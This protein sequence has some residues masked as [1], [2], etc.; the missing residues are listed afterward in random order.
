[1]PTLKRKR[2]LIV[3]RQNTTG[4]STYLS[5]RVVSKF[6]HTMQV[7]YLSSP[8]FVVRVKVTILYLDI[9]SSKQTTILES[10]E[11]CFLSAVKS[12]YFW[13]ICRSLLSISTNVFEYSSFFILGVMGLGACSPV[14]VRTLWVRAVD[15]RF[16][17]GLWRLL[18]FTGLKATLWLAEAKS[19]WTS[20]FYSSVLWVI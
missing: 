12:I 10:V 3:S 1:M 14:L 16:E 5:L 7:M 18:K 19:I 2:V 17:I 6:Q 9:M 4:S 11:V 8:V 13:S 15:V 20:F